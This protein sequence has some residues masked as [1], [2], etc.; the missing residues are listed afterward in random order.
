[1]ANQKM[2]RNIMVQQGVGKCYYQF[3]F[4]SLYKLHEKLLDH[5]CSGLFFKIK[6]DILSKVFK[7]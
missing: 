2:E 4:N 1:M 6:S 7:L 3:C 5:K